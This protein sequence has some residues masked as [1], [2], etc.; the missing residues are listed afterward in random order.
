MDT[1]RV[2]TRPFSLIR[3]TEVGSSKYTQGVKWG[4]VTV[5]QWGK[6]L[7]PSFSYTYVLAGK[8]SHAEEG[9][10]LRKKLF[11]DYR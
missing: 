1:D 6:G 5:D 10:E 11:F 9:F 3:Q 7:Q 4:A 8:A 2:L